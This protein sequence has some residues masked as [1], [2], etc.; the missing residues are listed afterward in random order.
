M[1]LLRKHV[2]LLTSLYTGIPDHLVGSVRKDFEVRTI[3]QFT[4]IG[5][6]FV[7]CNQPFADLLK[8]NDHKKDE[9]T[10]K[11][12][13][14]TEE[15]GSNTDAMSLEAQTEFNKYLEE[16]KFMG[17]ANEMVTVPMSEEDKVLL[18][19][20]FEM[21]AGKFNFPKGIVPELSQALGIE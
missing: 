13:D 2:S 15:D 4:K 12:Q 3:N 17:F 6:R 20:V 10:K 16:T 19:E 11:Y 8:E 7:E 18:K 9:I 21:H 1:E 14:I 5:E